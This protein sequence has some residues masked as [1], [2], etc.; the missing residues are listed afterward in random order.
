MT[1]NR[2]ISEKTIVIFTILA[3]SIILIFFIFFSKSNKLVL[4]DIYIDSSKNNRI[5]FSFVQV[6][7]YITSDMKEF[8]NKLFN[9]MVNK[10]TFDSSFVFI[11]TYFYKPNEQIPLTIDL[12]KQIEKNYLR[13]GLEID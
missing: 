3:F 10:N 1:G 6:S 7:D 9:Q 4:K 8:G 12:K 5:I 2:K 11:T 13:L